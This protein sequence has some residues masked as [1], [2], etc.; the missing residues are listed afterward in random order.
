MESLMQGIPGVLVYIDDIL[1][2]GSSEEE[3]LQ[4]LEQVLDRLQN[5]GLRVRKDKCIFMSPSVIYLGHKIDTEGLHP[6]ADKIKAIVDAPSPQ[7]VHELKSYLG[8]LSYYSKFMPNLATVLTPLYRLLRKE[9][10]W[11]WSQQEEEAFKHSK[12]C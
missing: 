9:T 8:L 2:T 3:H 10:R 6:L 1:V 4:A 5:S 11:R 7:N 12:I